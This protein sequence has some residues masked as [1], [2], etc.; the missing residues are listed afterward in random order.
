M[1]YLLKSLVLPNKISSCA[2]SAFRINNTVE[3]DG[4]S[5]S[6]SFK[7]YYSTFEDN[8]IKMLPKALNKY[9]VNTVIKYFENMIRGCHFNLAS[10]SEN[11][12]QTILKVTEVTRTAGFDIC[13]GVF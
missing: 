3:Y 1:E 6:N 4:N 10:V 12:I 5:V 13:L 2:V 7:N 8:L 11:S 9:P